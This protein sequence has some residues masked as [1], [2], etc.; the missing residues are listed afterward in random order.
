MSVSSSSVT[1]PPWAARARLLCC[2]PRPSRG[3]DVSRTIGLRF[4]M[5]RRGDCCMHVLWLCGRQ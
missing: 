2:A 1:A 5:P 3:Y 4:G